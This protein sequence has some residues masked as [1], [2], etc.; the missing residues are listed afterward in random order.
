[1]PLDQRGLWGLQVQLV[2]LAQLAQLG[3]LGL[4]GLIPRCQVLQGRLVL[5]VLLVLRGLRVR[6]PQFLAQL[7][8]Q[9]QRVQ[10]VR[11][12]RPG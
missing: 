11:K 8:L 6:R 12:E 3:Q 5:W 7:E 10:L 1:M 9:V 4:L 2:P